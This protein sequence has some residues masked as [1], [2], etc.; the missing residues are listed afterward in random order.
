MIIKWKNSNL[1]VY[2]PKLHSFRIIDRGIEIKA[3][4]WS[5]DAET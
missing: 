5:L 1:K 2:L 3:F 4:I